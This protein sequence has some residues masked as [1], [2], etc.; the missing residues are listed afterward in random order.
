MQ[1]PRLVAPPTSPCRI[2]GVPL[3]A[4]LL[5]TDDGLVVTIT[6]VA[7]TAGD[8]RY[9][10]AGV[11]VAA[12]IRETNE[13]RRRI[14]EYDVALTEWARTRPERPAN[15]TYGYDLEP[16]PADLPPPQLAEFLGRLPIALRDD[17]G[18][19]YRFS[20]GSTGGTDTEHLAE[21]LF[22]PV[23][24]DDA[25]NLTVDLDGEPSVTVSRGV[26]GTWGL[27]L[28]GNPPRRGRSQA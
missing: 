18:T 22:V 24:P 19:E 12:E 20:R 1:P 26:D 25:T 10:D 15:V 6:H 16:T 5:T 3:P 4:H 2:R 14:A 13:T 8:G 27:D 28:T 11:L 23:P 17:V 9:R 7:P 21:W